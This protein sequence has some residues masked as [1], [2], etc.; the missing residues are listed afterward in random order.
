MSQKKRADF[1]KAA[2]S[3]LVG[4]ALTPVLAGS[5]TI[6]T[7]RFGTPLPDP[8]TRLQLNMR[9]AGIIA[10][11]DPKMDIAYHT[12]GAP[13]TRG[14]H[15]FNNGR[16][17]IIDGCGSNTN[18][19]T[20]DCGIGSS[21]P[22]PPPP[23]PPPLIEIG[24]TR[25]NN[26]AGNGYFDMQFGLPSTCFLQ[27]TSNVQM[28]GGKSFIQRV[29]DD[30]WKCEG[31]TDKVIAATLLITRHVIAN[32]GSY[33]SAAV[34]AARQAINRWTG[35]GLGIA[36]AGEFLWGFATLV[37][38]PEWAALLAL[39]GITAFTVLVAYQCWQGN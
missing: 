24:R 7:T 29:S 1:L 18:S 37:T 12:F 38:L 36:A 22:P 8:I 21:P 2:G 10:A 9:Q 11:Y 6:R 39:A 4:V 31:K 20:P 17:I 15:T 3:G 19:I 27:Y 28:P 13:Y 5:N 34:T 32:A 25:A 14:Y 23:A 26:G 16:N 33:S 35:T 30:Y